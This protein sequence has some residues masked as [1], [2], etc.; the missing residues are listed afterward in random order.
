MIRPC[1]WEQPVESKGCHF[2]TLIVDEAAQSPGLE[3]VLL[4]PGMQRL[5]V[6]GRHLTC[7]PY[8]PHSNPDQ[9]VLEG[10]SNA[11]CTCAD[12]AEDCVQGSS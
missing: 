8:S 12:Q 11:Y 10:Y 1:R 3:R 2:G 4:A 5:A 9:K 7:F 6:P